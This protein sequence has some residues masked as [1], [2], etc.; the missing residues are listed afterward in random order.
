MSSE[1]LR[2]FAPRRLLIVDDDP[3]TCEILSDHY[4]ALGFT[5]ELADN[6][7]SALLAVE[8]Q[9]PDIILCDR[10]MPNGSGAELL[11]E[12]RARGS[13]W[14][15]L[16]FLFVTSLSSHRDRFAMLDLKP[17]G[18]IIKPIDFNVVDTRLVDIL[19]SRPC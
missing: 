11:S 2:T 15:S 13:E 4:S 5:V 18:Y 8:R 3:M 9:R 1:A 7:T 19:R 6:G 16:V 10:I 17:D 12:I 14:Q